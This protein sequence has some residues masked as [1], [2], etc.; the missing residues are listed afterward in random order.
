M[1]QPNGGTLMHEQYKLNEA[2]HF[3]KRMGNAG[4]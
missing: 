1:W 2:L 4:A 3:L